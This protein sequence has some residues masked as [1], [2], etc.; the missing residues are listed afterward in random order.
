[1]T[2]PSR[3]API[4]GDL[5]MRYIRYISEMLIVRCDGAVTW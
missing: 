3:E 2:A 4:P 5:I 1:M